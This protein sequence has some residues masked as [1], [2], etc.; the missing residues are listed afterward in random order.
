MGSDLL[1]TELVSKWNAGRRG[2]AES[3]L[4]RFWWASF[5]EGIGGAAA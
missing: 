2:V 1:R 5:H 4:W 3:V